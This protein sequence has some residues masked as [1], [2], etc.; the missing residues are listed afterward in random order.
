MSDSITSQTPAS[1]SCAATPATP[2]APT[3]PQAAAT[4]GAGFIPAGFP[5]RPVSLVLCGVGGQGTILA[6][7]LLARAALG[8]G[9]DVKVSEIHG[10]AQ[11]GGSVSTTVRFG[12]RVS[13]MVCGPSAAD[14]VLS[15]EVLE[16]IRNLPFL[17]PGGHL[18]C[19]DVV[20][21]PMS[22]LAG[23]ASMPD[24]PRGLLHELGRDAVEIVDADAIARTAGNARCA[25]VALLGA[26]ARHLPISLD[27]W[28]AAIEGRVPPKTVEANLRAFDAAYAGR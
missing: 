10:M 6:A 2:G 13:S 25:N 14:V 4:T 18:V 8:S 3:V 9:F 12:E 23:L 28:H 26:A 7:D 1:P 21:E 11:R 19:A 16:A 24:D 22:V 27:A 15:L 20:T 17:A 5:Q